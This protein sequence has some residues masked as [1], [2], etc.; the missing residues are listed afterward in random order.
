MIKQTSEALHGI[1]YTKL[2]LVYLSTRVCSKSQSLGGYTGLQKYSTGGK[3]KIRYENHRSGIRLINM[4][5]FILSSTLSPPLTKRDLL[6]FNRG[7]QSVTADR[8][9][10]LY[11]Y[12]EFRET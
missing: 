10:W 4:K 7:K 1:I 5:I 3:I 9:V 6:V 12:N 8:F 11:P 2:C